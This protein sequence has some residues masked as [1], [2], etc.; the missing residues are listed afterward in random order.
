MSSSRSTQNNNN[1][2]ESTKS[3]S[4]RILSPISVNTYV[5][6]D[7]NH[8]FNSSKNDN[9]ALS[10]TRKSLSFN[11]H[12]T[13]FREV[14]ISQDNFVGDHIDLLSENKVIVKYILNILI[15]KFSFF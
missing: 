4:G 14:E 1:S 10:D 11:T 7:L 13:R 2:R 15:Y 12:S 8:D 5:M 3:L 6:N 9:L